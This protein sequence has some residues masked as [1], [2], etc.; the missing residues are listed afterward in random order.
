MNKQWR[1]DQKIDAQN[2]SSTQVTA[3]ISRRTGFRVFSLGLIGCFSVLEIAAQDPSTMIP[4]AQ[5]HP[6]YESKIHPDLEMYYQQRRAT[7][8]IQAQAATPPTGYTRFSVT[9]QTINIP[10]E[11]RQMGTGELLTAFGDLGGTLGS[12]AFSGWLLIFLLRQSDKERLEMREAFGREREKTAAAHEK[13]IHDFHLEREKERQ[14]F[15]E[16]RTTHLSKD[17]SN[18]EAMRMAME[19]SQTNLLEIVKSTQSTIGEL[20]KVLEGHS[21]ELKASILELKMAIHTQFERTNSKL[22]SWDGEDRRDEG[23]ERRS[24]SSRTRRNA[25]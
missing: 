15:Q 3:A 20:S 10:M 13:Q 22:E 8:A 6:I 23:N 11:N 16:E 19:K 1:W 5:N 18:D 9:P 17:S 14:A 7:E 24:S 4:Q 2:R 25:G 21:H 12:L